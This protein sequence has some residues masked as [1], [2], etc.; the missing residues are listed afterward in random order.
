M[1]VGIDCR[2]ASTTSGLGRYTRELVTHLLRRKD[3]IQYTLFVRSVDEGW[4][5]SLVGSP[6]PYHLHPITC[7]HYSLAEQVLFPL[8]IRHSGIDLLFSLHF[9]VP[10]LCPVPFVATVHDLI[11]HRY[12]N[13]VPF[14]KRTAY[15]W[16]MRHTVTHARAL[17]A[18]S[19]FVRSEIREAYSQRAVSKVTVIHEGV[20]AQFF[21]RLERE[22]EEV[23]RKYALR[24]PFFLYVGNAKEHKNV[25]MLIHAFQKLRS[26]ERTLVLVTSGREADGLTTGEHIRRLT[27]VAE[28]D[29]PALYSA[30]RAFVTPSLYEGF[31]LPIAEA[32]ACGCPVIACTIGVMPEVVGQDGTLV[33]AT[34][35]ALTLALQAP[36]PLVRGLYQRRWEV[37]AEETVHRLLTVQS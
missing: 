34:E 20:D 19:Q 27:H 3:P 28:E 5:Q 6:T 30:A 13:E 4:I 2:F 14:W 23:L 7:S 12:P 31:C 22:Q 24:P 25:P 15:R 11:L 26:S 29:L 17:I 1:H 37:V 9:N 8:A 35:E 36:P 33:E 18:V 16:V 21:Y 10:L 32:R